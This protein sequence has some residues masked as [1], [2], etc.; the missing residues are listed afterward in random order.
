MTELAPFQP[1]TP[2]M[3]V[4]HSTGAS[5]PPLGLGEPFALRGGD[6]LGPGGITFELGHDWQVDLCDT[7]AGACEGLLAAERPWFRLPPTALVGKGTGRTHAGRSLARA[8]G[9]PHIIL[10]L[11]DPVIAM[12]VA[13]SGE[14][15]E[16]L[17]VSPIV[18]AM[19]ATRCA[20]PVVSVVGAEHNA[21]AAMALVTMID[22]ALGRACV[23]GPYRYDGRSR[24]GELADPGL[25]HRSAACAARRAPA[26]GADASRA[27]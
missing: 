11:S 14:I 23:R 1:A 19:A 2:A 8:V 6:Q 7:V 21:D 24:R 13:G 27:G 15:N 25:R 18:T 26:G 5:V 3:I 17:W 16:A 9:V 22:P 10:N 12:N 4:G 20:N